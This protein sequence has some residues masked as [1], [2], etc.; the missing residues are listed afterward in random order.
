[1][2]ALLITINTVCASII[3]MAAVT[4]FLHKDYDLVA[5]YVFFVVLICWQIARSVTRENDTP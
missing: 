1:M 3:S 4:A 2:K 5:A